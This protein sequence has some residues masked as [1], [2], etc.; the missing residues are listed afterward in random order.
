MKVS[1]EQRVEL[2]KGIAA[3]DGTYER[4]EFQESGWMV[5]EKLLDDLEAAEARI[6]ELQN[7]LNE[8]FPVF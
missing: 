1:P 6:T 3:E 7:E 5:V 4:G 2:R 8:P